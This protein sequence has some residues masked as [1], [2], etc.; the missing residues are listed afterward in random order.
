LH[1]IGDLQNEA[2]GRGTS[3]QEGIYPKRISIPVMAQEFYKILEK[4]GRNSEGRLMMNIAMK[5]NL[6][7]LFRYAKVGLKLFRGARC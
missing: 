7:Q 5:T 3:G 6:F 4:Q 2:H 1:S